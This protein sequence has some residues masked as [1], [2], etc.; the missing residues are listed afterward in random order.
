MLIEI[1]A[2]PRGSW[3]IQNGTNSSI[4]RSLIPIAK[5]LGLKAVDVVQRAKLLDEK[6]TCGDLVVVS[7]LSGITLRVAE[8]TMN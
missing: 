3:V 5:S 1:V 2:L 4:A 8:T 7:K 6:A